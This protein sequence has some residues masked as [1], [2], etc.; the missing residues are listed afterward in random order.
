M[1]RSYVRVGIKTSSSTSA[2]GDVDV[3]VVV[4]VVEGVETL[5]VD[6]GV[7][8]FF[9]NKEIKCFFSI[10]LIKFVITKQMGECEFLAI[11]SIW[12]WS[13]GPKI[14]SKI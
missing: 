12:P 1:L 4:A 6:M 2:D 14:S 10:C 13:F 8:A 3:S 5:L 9:F 11:H 7:L